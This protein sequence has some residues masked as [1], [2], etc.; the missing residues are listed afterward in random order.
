MQRGGKALAWQGHTC[1]WLLRQLPP[2]CCSSPSRAAASPAELL[3]PAPPVGWL[4]MPTKP[5]RAPTVPPCPCSGS[6]ERVG[7]DVSKVV[8]KVPHMWHMAPG[9]R[10]GATAMDCTVALLPGGRVRRQLRQAARGV[11]MTHM[12]RW[13]QRLQQCTPATLYVPGRHI[14]PAAVR[15]SGPAAP[16]SSKA[17]TRLQPQRLTNPSAALLAGRCPPG[18]QM[19][20][21]VRCWRGGRGGGAAC[22]PFLA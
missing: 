3:P 8:S 6:K 11:A 13:G 15:P 1:L 17:P 9:C 5:R 7:R 4:C 18:P 19:H 22:A 16:R 10:R 21:P 20:R 12:A 2:T 14:R